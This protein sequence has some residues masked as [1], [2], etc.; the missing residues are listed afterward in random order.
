MS[1]LVAVERL[2]SEQYDEDDLS[3]IPDLIE[4]IRLQGTGPTEAARAIRKKLKYGNVHRQLR[5]LTILDGLI[6]NAGSRFQRVFADEPLLERLRVA[7]SDP[8]S[9]PEVRAKCKQL[10][11]QWSVAYKDT[12]GMERVTALYRQLPQRKK[13][14]PV[15][16]QQS[17]VLQETEADVA[18][19]T[20]N[21]SDDPHGRSTSSHH[22][23]KRTSLSVPSSSK[24][25]TALSPTSS[26]PVSLSAAPNLLGKTKKDKKSKSKGTPFN[27]EKEKPQMLQSIA[28]ASVASTN[29]TNALK[30]VNREQNRVSDDP[31]VMKRFEVCKQLRRQILR[32]IQFVESD[33]YLGGLIH[34]NDELVNALMAFEILDKS[35][36][37]DSDSELEE[38]KHLSRIHAGGHHSPPSSP[39]R[40]PDHAFAG[41]H[42]SNSDETSA[43]PKPPRPTS[44]PMPPASYIAAGKARQQ[45]IESDQS[46]VSEEEEEEEEEEDNPFGDKNAAATPMVEPKAYTWK[47]V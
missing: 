10:F 8:V 23:T 25:T 38:G 9:D 20:N 14:M 18:D 5:A 47:E 39:S 16:Q 24:P 15:R 40:A 46:D 28:G 45:E 7:G 21:R 42:I 2:T 1:H 22:T 6:Q 33:D 17:K 27:L 43:P 26:G 13:P 29:L 35:I 31:E 34:A 19:D 30:L 11:A 44:I 41:L 36:D 12:P 32:Y 3:G 37:D 4:V